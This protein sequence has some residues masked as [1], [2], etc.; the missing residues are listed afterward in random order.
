M[1]DNE[2]VEEESQW[3]ARYRGMLLWSA[4]LDFDER[5]WSVEDDL[6]A[7]NAALQQAQSKDNNIQALLND[8]PDIT[9][10]QTR[11]NRYDGEVQAL[12]NNN[13]KLMAS[14]EN[15]IRAQLFAALALQR[16]R[17]QFYLAEARLALAQLYDNKY[18]EG[19]KQ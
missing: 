10:A 17:V 19:T 8:A 13:T 3:L 12:I 18:L 7:I 16:Q 11:I 14:I 5:L 6:K 2:N 4:S 15:N 1:N 9:A